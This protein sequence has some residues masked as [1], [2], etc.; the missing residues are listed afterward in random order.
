MAIP[1][2]KDIVFRDIHAKKCFLND[3]SIA[4]DKN[5]SLKEIGEAFKRQRPRNRY[6]LNAESEKR[7]DSHYSVRIMLDKNI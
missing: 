3:I 2:A 1:T 7:C 4:A 5:G 6:N